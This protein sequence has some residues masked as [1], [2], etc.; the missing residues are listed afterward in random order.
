[1]IRHLSR[2]RIISPPFELC[3]ILIVSGAEYLYYFIKYSNN[4]D[5]ILHLYVRDLIKAS[6]PIHTALQNAMER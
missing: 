6:E 5:L 3:I 2:G 4:C 1:M